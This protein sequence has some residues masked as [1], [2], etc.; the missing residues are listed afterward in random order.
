M[1]N[2]HEP[3]H[4][5][6]RSDEPPR[7]GVRHRRP[8]VRPRHQPPRQ[9]R[10]GNPPRRCTLLQRLILRIRQPQRH[11]PPPPGR[12]RNPRPGGTRR[13]RRQPQPG[14]QRIPAQPSRTAAR[15]DPQ[16]R[17]LQNE[18]PRARPAPRLPPEQ[19]R[20]LIDPD[21]PR[22]RL[23]PTPAQPIRRRFSPVPDRRRNPIRRHRDR[24]EP[25]REKLINSRHPPVRPAP[26]PVSRVDLEEDEN[27]GCGRCGKPRSSRF[28]RLPVGALLASMGSGGVHSPGAG[29]RQCVRIA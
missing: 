16:P 19:H 1:L 12:K 8:S 9:R 4:D 29:D 13:P 15:P 18:V 27:D 10:G 7:V 2:V 11:L 20:Q 21:L 26:V 17:Q 6:R 14:R 5:Q 28:S 22:P 3:Q 25:L 24:T 23:L